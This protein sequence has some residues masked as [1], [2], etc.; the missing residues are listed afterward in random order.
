[1]QHVC[2]D[3]NIRLFTRWKLPGW[4]SGLFLQLWNL[5]E[6]DATIVCGCFFCLQ[7][8]ERQWDICESFDIRYRH[9]KDILYAPTEN[10]NA[11]NGATSSMSNNTHSQS[12]VDD[13][14]MF[15]G[16]IKSAPTFYLG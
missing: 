8:S 11:A 14:A 4:P 9:G 15:V 3:M 1:M 2:T 7:T 12:S 13:S 10:S 16:D 5:L 6:S